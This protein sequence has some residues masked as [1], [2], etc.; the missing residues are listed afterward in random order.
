MRSGGCG[1]GW[2][3]CGS[4]GVVVG[5]VYTKLLIVSRDMD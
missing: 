2:Q 4:G 1:G 5:A 3:A